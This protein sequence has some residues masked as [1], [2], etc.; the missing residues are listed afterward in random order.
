M[1]NIKKSS[2]KSFG[3]VFFIVFILIAFYPLLNREEI[4]LWALVTAM[5]FLVLGIKNSIL[6]LPLNSIWNSLG[7]FLGKFVSPLIMGIV[8]FAVVFPTY[9][10]V[11]IFKRN[12][13]NI[14]YEKNKKTY[15]VD[16]KNK[17]NSMDNQF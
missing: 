14:K 13:L 5:V 15:W 11:S 16:V 8:Y 9:I 3:I 10:L 4:R 7:F 1:D 6:L 17:Y 12:Y 2:N